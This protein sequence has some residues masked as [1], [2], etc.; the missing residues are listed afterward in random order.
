MRI[1]GDRLEF[2]VPAA[3]AGQPLVHENYAVR[4]DISMAA[5]LREAFNTSE[6]LMSGYQHALIMTDGDSMLVPADEYDERTAEE[7]YHYTFS[8]HRQ[9]IVLKS[10]LPH[11]ESVVV[12]SMNKD[13]FSV[14]VEHFRNLS[15]IPLCQPVWTYLHR[16]SFTGVRPKL[17]VYF[18]ERSMEIFCYQHNRFKFCNT[19]DATHEPDVVYFILHVWRLMGYSNDLAEL[20]LLGD[21]PEE[22]KTKSDL[23]KYLNR[24]YTIDAATE[25]QQ[26]HIS[27]FKDLPFDRI[28]L[29]MQE[30]ENNNRQI[31]RQEI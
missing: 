12:F 14:I 2:S 13:L 6:L 4:P 11:L 22:E 7:L 5:N 28:T 29:Y 15:I 1:A 17:F 25:F 26:S 8:G 31:Q 18:H 23:G 21:I 20:Y 16:R 27:E 10:V 3:Q 30:N 19:F 9:D 24:V